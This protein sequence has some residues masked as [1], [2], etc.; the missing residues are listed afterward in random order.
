MKRKPVRINLSTKTEDVI[1]TMREEMP[2]AS[3]YFRKKY[4]GNQKYLKYEDALL[5]K[6]LAEE[7][8]QLTDIEYY[9]SPVGNRWMTYTHVMYFPRAKHAHA[10]HWSFVYYETI[11]SCGAFFPSYS[12][13]QIKD[14]MVKK[15]GKPDEVIVFTSHF[16]FQ[17]S[18]RTKIEYRSKELIKKF[19][20][21]KCENAMSIGDDGEVIAKLDSGH[22][23]GK[24][25][26]R[27]PLRAE[28]R[29]YLN[30]QG[31]N[32]HQRERVKPVDDFY[33][34]MKDGMFMKPVAIG[35]AIN[36]LNDPEKAWKEGMEKLEVL[37]K[38]NLER[39]AIMIAAIHCAFVRVLEKLLHMELT[40]EQSAV[41]AH[42]VGDNAKDTVMKFGKIEHPT[43]ADNAALYEAMIDIYAKTAKQM[44]LKSVTRPRIADCMQ[45]IIS[46]YKRAEKLC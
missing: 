18:E 30:D 43:E 40:M 39:E 45:A 41:I 23:F 16:F 9:I 4:G 34:L 8:D 46:T 11:G 5:D 26:S 33:K 37:K 19:I 1:A 15:N 24:V 25:M 22:G 38:F 42:L 31:L 13:K 44:H 7:K 36:S 12:A 21:E 28:V 6:A 10:F 2:H 35:T 3:Y 27:N 29:T 20:S 17:L 14:G 32:K